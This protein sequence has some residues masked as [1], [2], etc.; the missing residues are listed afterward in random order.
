MNPKISL[1]AKLLL[2]LLLTLLTFNGFAQNVGINT[3]GNVPDASA[4]LDVSSTQQGILIPRMTTAER[5]ALKT[6]AAGLIIY[7]TTTNTLNIY[8]NTAWYVFESISV[9][10]TT[11]S[12]APGSGVAINEDGSAPA[13]CAILEV[14][15]SIRGFLLPRTNTSSIP[16]LSQGL[17]I[18]NTDTDKLTYYDGSVW[19]T[20]CLSF[21]SATTGAG[22]LTPAGVSINEIGNVADQSA[23]LDVQSTNK[24][25]LIPRLTNAQ[26][27]DLSP[28]QGL[29]F[30][31][32]TTNK[33]NYWNSTTWQEVQ[34][35]APA[36]PGT[37]SG[38]N[39]VCSGDA[40]EVYS[41]SSVSGATSY[42][43]S[44]PS[45]A[46]ITAGQGTTSITVTWGSTS[47][48]VNVTAD[49]GCGNSGAQTFAVTVTTLPVATF[50]YT[51]T[52]Y[53]SSATDPSP[54]FS[55]GGVAG[56][57]TSTASLAFVSTATGEVDISASTAG[58]YTVTNTIA[59]VGGCGVVTATSPIT[60]HPTPTAGITNNT[61]TTILTCTT[62][63]IAVTATGGGSY[64]WS[65]GA[66]P[67]TAANSLTAA[68]TYTVT[69]TAANG[70]TATSSI[71]ITQNITAPT[72]APS[73]LANPICS[74]SSTT[75]SANA[76]AGSGSITTYAWSSGIAGNNA[77]GTVSVAGTYTVTVTNS[78]GCTVAAT[79]PSLTLNTA[80]TAPTGISG[81]TT[82]CAGTTTIL[83]ATGGSEGSGC[84][85]Q[86]GTGSTV[87][88]NIIAGA[89]S[90][91]YT[92]PALAT[93]TRYWVR[94]VGTAPCSNTTSGVTQLITVT[95]IPA[96]PG[97][98]TGDNSVCS[99]DVGDVY[100]ISSVS[101]ATS[102]TWAVPSGAT[103][104][105]GQSTT[106]ITVTWGSTSG[107]VSVYA[108]NGC[109]NS[110]TRTFAVTVNSN[111]SASASSNTPVCEG[112]D[113]N[114]NSSP[115]GE[116]Y[117]WSGPNFS[118]T[119]EDPTNSD[120]VLADAGAYYVT[121]TDGNGC[122]D[123]ATASVTV[124]AAPTTAAAGSDI[125]PACDATTATLA[126]NTPTVGTG[127][128]SVVSGTATV[129]TPSSNT[130]GV[131]GLAVPGTATLRWTISNSPC[132]A[133]ID[134]VVITTTACFSCGGTLAI[135]HT[136]GTVAPVDKTVS[137]GTVTS[138]LSGASKCW[139][140]QNLGSSNQA[141]SATD[142]TEA[143]AG[144][145]WQFNRKQGFKHDGT[146]LTPSWTTTS[147]DEDSDWLAAND[148]CTIELGTGWRIP[149]KT[150]WENAD[151]NG[152][153]VDYDND[154]TGTFGSVLKLHA[155]GF[156]NYSNGSL[157]NRGTFGSYWSST[158]TNSTDGWY[159]NFFSSYSFMNNSNKAF[160][161]SLRCLRD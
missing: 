20:P 87:G 138:S 72:A 74:G 116:S 125:N 69:V 107:N 149:T 81:T 55:G 123:V 24:G 158:Q 133:S 33:L 155:A 102:Y 83:S 10:A 38:T 91:S 13:N 30:Y 119:S 108:S 71:T 66:T 21:S 104:T 75:L 141:S 67:S 31:N 23:M 18:Y 92:T 124:N 96:T 150:E 100:S 135:T 22:T 153:W 103:I 65:G 77:S 1:S 54:T 90:V 7:N 32:T 126:G 106:S 118:S 5:D 114:L 48:N 64:S 113:I 43:W 154:A 50:S 151:A 127:A 82:I 80:P 88:A 40:G 3:T 26:R 68:G 19:K 140:T 156:L 61:A 59:A 142:A 121:V 147:I 36:T 41:I 35:S 145:Y 128:W 101:G 42:T 12:T 139:I 132:T 56:T 34:N 93:S 136:A 85:Y 16:T 111:P 63:A 105:S 49:N 161:F 62:T 94:R 110:G 157:G 152:G 109:G 76:T 143:S 134:D 2:I 131:T 45:G 52:P 46:S 137:Y 144:W 130:S 29:I 86:W 159:L 60:V 47:G 129:T 53:C 70:C 89:T 84:T 27:D 73:F 17:I 112:D 148:P 97:T 8:D 14:E 122:T 11:G 51:G 4:I 6:P 79:S 160:G 9:G 78:I 28:V 39:P 95:S 117:N 44:V 58:T 15:S 120:A 99:G 25:L 98:I 37:I 115:S 146:T 57:F